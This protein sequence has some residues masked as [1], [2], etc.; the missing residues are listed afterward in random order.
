MHYGGRCILC[1]EV[2]RTSWRWISARG[3]GWVNS[4]FMCANCYLPAVLNQMVP[5]GSLQSPHPPCPMELLQTATLSHTDLGLE[6]TAHT[7]THTHT[8]TPKA[9][10]VQAA[11]LMPG[12]LTLFSS[13]FGMI[14]WYRGSFDCLLCHWAPNMHIVK[15]FAK[16][17]VPYP[18]DNLCT[19][20]LNKKEKNPIWQQHWTVN[21]KAY[22]FN[23][24]W[25]IIVS[26]SWT[27]LAC[28]HILVVIQQC[29]QVCLD[30]LKRHP[31]RLESSKMHTLV[32][33]S[34]QCLILIRAL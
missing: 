32:F 2:I 30:T 21:L 23:I 8:C 18:S 5:L 4:D 33:L 24:S 15:H 22:L 14:S 1:R 19:V 11:K 27:L 17:Q 28:V 25:N 31:L 10:L 3:R 20:G 9:H 13:S 7:H 26:R 16:S 34:S 6:H 29:L 12:A